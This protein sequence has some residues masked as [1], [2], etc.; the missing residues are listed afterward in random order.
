[1]VA[2]NSPRKQSLYIPIW[3]YSNYKRYD[4]CGRWCSFTFQY[5][6]IQIMSQKIQQTERDFFTFQYGSIQ[7]IPNLTCG[8]SDISLYIPIWFYSNVSSIFFSFFCIFFTFQ[9]GSIQILFMT[10]VPT[11][12]LLYIPIWFYSNCNKYMLAILINTLHS[13]MVLFK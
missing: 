4:I 8:L 9:Y 13:N 12:S 2:F 3:F 10:T 11:Q 1:M 6:S 7:I 5:G